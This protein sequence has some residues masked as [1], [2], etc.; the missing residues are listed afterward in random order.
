MNKTMHAFSS[1]LLFAAVVAHPKLIHAD[2][3]R[4][5]PPAPQNKTPYIT[6]TQPKPNL[7]PE[8]INLLVKLFSK[9]TT[10]V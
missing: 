4:L 5:T 8:K 2:T 3:G 1:L 10:A 7:V 9:H 6:P